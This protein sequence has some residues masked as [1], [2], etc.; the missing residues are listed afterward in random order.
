MSAVRGIIFN[1]DNVLTETSENLYLAWK[2]VASSI[3]IHMDRA[4]FE[5]IKGLPPMKALEL[6]L[7]T[8]GK[9]HDFSR[10]EMLRLTMTVNRHYVDMIS[11]YSS[12]NLMAGVKD[13]LESMSSQDIR[14][15]FI[16]A[17]M[18]TKRLAQILGI[19]KYADYI[20][21]S[22]ADAEQSLADRYLNAVRG[23]KLEAH[24]CIG[25]D[26]SPAGIEAIKSAGLLAV[27]IG[28][29]GFLPGADKVYESTGDIEP[30]SLF[31]MI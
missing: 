27:G 16:S 2:L 19:D 25:V 1:M 18:G 3:G 11:C 28:D 4:H 14:V 15:A 31:E 5:R 21:E 13:L 24:Q 9:E 22:L 30:L 8:D 29:I 7:V 23:L 17:S 6:I 20:P 12:D 26:E 10:Q